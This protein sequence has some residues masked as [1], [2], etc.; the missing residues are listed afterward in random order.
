MRSKYIIQVN[1]Q[2]LELFNSKKCSNKNIIMSCCDEINRK[3]AF[4]N[5][6]FYLTFMQPNSLKYF[7]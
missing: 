6:D 7:N 2:K 3:F 5:D 1:K 4:L